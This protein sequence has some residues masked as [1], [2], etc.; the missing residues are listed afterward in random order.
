[1]LDEFTVRLLRI[2]V[3]AGVATALLLCSAVGG[4]K[5]RAAWGFIYGYLIQL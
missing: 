3:F 2:K 4:E 1:M 5:L